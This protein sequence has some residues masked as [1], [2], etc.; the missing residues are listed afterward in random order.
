MNIV[1]CI[2]QVPANDKVEIDKESGTLK[3]MG[4]ES[5]INPYD[6]FAIETALQIKEKLG[7]VVTAITMGPSQCAEMMKDVF[8]MGVDKGV[9]I[10]DKKFAGAD[11]LATS[12][13]L[14]Q[15]ISAIGKADIII[16]GKQTTDGDTAQVGPSI[17]E[18]LHIP[19]IAWVNE[20][21]DIN[22]REIVVRQNFESF[23]QV[24]KMEYPALITVEKDI[25]VPRLPS[26]KLMKESK[27]KEPIFLSF[28][29]MPDKDLSRYG[30][31]GSP[32]VVEKIFPPNPDIKQVYIEGENKDK[33]I[34]DILKEKKFVQGV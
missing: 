13:T 9:I 21:V 30:L 6:L 29:D 17:A 15:G 28:E 23:S 26:Y 33:Q 12:Y 1:V 34:F 4:A 25:N 18:H 8:S 2:K 22:E 19:H 10:S 24:S 27:G 32:T 5:K 14:S 3:R 31:V 7:G 20:I 11:V 16:C